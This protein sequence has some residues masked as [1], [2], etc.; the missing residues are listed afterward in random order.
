MFGE[1]RKHRLEMKRVKKV[2]IV[3]T[4]TVSHPETFKVVDFNM[5]K[6]LN[7][8]LNHLGHKTSSRA[9][10]ER[11]CK[12]KYSAYCVSDIDDVATDNLNQQETEA[13]SQEVD[14]P[15]INIKVPP[16]GDLKQSF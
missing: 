9:V 14:Q 10:G 8:F 7:V 13:V 5:F 12:H 15:S 2:R 6:I 3:R 16:M 11:L 4:G 1:W